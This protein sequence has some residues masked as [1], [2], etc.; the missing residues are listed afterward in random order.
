MH[1]VRL[2]NAKGHAA[3]DLMIRAIFIRKLFT[4]GTE[5]FLHQGIHYDL[6]ADCM[7]CHFPHELIRPSFLCIGIAGG[8]LEFLII[9]V[10]LDHG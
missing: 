7:S 5:M 10:H 6:F 8:V 1:V 9:L 4:F 2:L 3:T